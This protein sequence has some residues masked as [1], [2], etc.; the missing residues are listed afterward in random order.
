[1]VKKWLF[2]QLALWLYLAL[3]SITWQSAHEKHTNVLNA[4]NQ[5]RWNIWKLPVAE[6]AVPYL[7]K[8]R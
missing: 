4:A 8:R 3:F 5:S 1:M 2:L 7:K 6:C